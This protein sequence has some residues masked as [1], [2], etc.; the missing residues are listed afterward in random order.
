M[1]RQPQ[2]ELD[3]IFRDTS[4]HRYSVMLQLMFAV[5]SFLAMTLFHVMTRFQWVALGLIFYAI[6]VK[7]VFSALSEVVSHSQAKSRHLDGYDDLPHV[8]STRKMTFI[9]FGG[10]ILLVSLMMRAGPS[11][12]GSFGSKVGIL[13]FLFIIGY[14]IYLAIWR[15][16]ARPNLA[17]SRQNALHTARSVAANSLKDAAIHIF[18]TVLIIAVAAFLFFMWADFGY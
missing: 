12:H 2:S 3:A 14:R 7:L 11:A 17:P 15:P 5:I 9:V 8:K 10:A 4:G 13:I 18:M 6:P 16:A 1:L